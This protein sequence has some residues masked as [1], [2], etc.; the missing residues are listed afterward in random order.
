MVIIELEPFIYH[1]IITK[2]PY[3]PSVKYKWKSLNLYSNIKLYL[4]LYC[5]FISVL[6]KIWKKGIVIIIHIYGARTIFIIFVIDNT[7]YLPS[8]K[9]KWSFLW[10]SSRI[11]VYQSLTGTV[12]SIL[13]KRGGNIVVIIHIYWSRAIFII[14]MI[15]KTP[16]LPS[17]KYKWVF[18]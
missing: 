12:I 17:V 2:T 1:F 18:L 11:K 7:P 6:Y 15:S 3:L 8:V 14:S 13:Y 9:Y 5:T 16:Y 10:Y 4:R